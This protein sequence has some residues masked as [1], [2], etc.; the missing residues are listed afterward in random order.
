MKKALPWIALALALM[1]IIHNPA[2]AGNTIHSLFT[3]LTTFAAS[4]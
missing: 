3:G 1:W 4:L 2:G